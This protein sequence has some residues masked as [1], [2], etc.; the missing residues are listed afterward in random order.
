MAGVMAEAASLCN[1]RHPVA[2]T[3]TPP[4]FW[5]GALIR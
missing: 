4:R 3:A 1:H 5:G 2:K